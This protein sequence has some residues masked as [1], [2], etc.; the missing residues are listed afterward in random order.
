VDGWVVAD[1]NLCQLFSQQA[2]AAAKLSVDWSTHSLYDL[3]EVLAVWWAARELH[4]AWAVATGGSFATPSL[5]LAG[6]AVT[7]ATET[8][9]GT[10]YTFLKV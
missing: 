7:T 4:G 2:A 9:N 3:N 6:S 10:S 8:I 1:W 5:T